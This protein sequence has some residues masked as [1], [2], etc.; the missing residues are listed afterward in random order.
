MPTA[1]LPR[2]CDV[3]GL[4][5]AL[6]D[7]AAIAG[8]WSALV[9]KVPKNAFLDMG[10]MAFL[11]AWAGGKRQEGR[12]I[13]LRGSNKPLGY[14]ARMDLHEHVGMDYDAGQRQ[15]EKGRF[16]PLKQVSTDEDVFTTVNAISDLV[17][18]QFDNAA[19]F[20]PAVEWAVCELIDNIVIH[21]E[22]P[23]PGAV[24]AQFFPKKQRLDIGICDIGRGIK[25]SLE[26]TRT[27]RS[28]GEAITMALQRG[29]T[30]DKAVGQGNGMAGSLDIARANGGRFHIWSGDV[31]YRVEGGRERG[32][33]KIP[34]VPGTGIMLSLDTRNAV[35]LSKTWIG[36]SE[37]CFINVEAERI[38]QAGGINVADA[39]INT[40]TRRPA[41]RLR[42][43]LTALLP[44]ME[45]PLVLDF[46]DVK[47][48]SSSFLDELLGRLADELGR[49][50]FDKRVHCTGMNPTIR[51]MAN[52]V[53]AQRLDGL[54][55]DA[56]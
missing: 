10:A 9:I 53:I 5:E 55:P 2:N 13:H 41:K 43:K 37:W 23:V 44:E 17:L 21:S 33:V 19:A 15:D 40:G 32:F 49:D 54:S 26:T 51:N 31:V 47:S 3:A 25:R 7:A 6:N 39:C 28:H 52:V 4:A 46:H 16:L 20:L 30:R 45:E 50:V 11:C 38:E 36:D 24:C 48:A 42:R 8:D 27:L 29:V 1:A 56:S 22:T 34:E 18:Q 14:L 12:R 35:D